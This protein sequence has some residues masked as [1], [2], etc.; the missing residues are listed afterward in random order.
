VIPASEAHGHIGEAAAVCGHV[1]SAA[2]FASVGGR[3]TFINLDRPYPDQ[4]FTVVIWERARALFDVPPERL[5]DGKSICVRGTIETYQGKP[6][7]VVE[8]PAQI[9][10]R[11][12]FTGGQELTATERIFIKSV[13]SALGYEANYGS[14][15]W[16]EET[17]EAVVAFQEDCGLPVTG[18]PDPTTL[19][20][21]ASRVGEIASEDRD[22][23]IRLLLF[24]F[25]RRQE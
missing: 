6:Q 16:D 9:E 17:V 19:R 10:V 18:E 13:L 15:E 24:E 5:L 2:Y 23:V 11:D 25:V 12:P 7:I 3:P 4:T 20:A 21:L 8:D 14:S 1:A 22:L